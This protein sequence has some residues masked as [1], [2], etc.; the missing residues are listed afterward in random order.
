MTNMGHGTTV[1]GAAC[2]NAFANGKNKGVAP[3]A[4]IIMVET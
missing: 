2:G 4:D 3:K 1:T